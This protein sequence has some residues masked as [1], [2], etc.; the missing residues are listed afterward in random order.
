M[1]R[2]DEGFLLLARKPCSG[3]RWVWLATMTALPTQIDRLAARDEAAL[4]HGSGL[5]KKVSESHTSGSFVSQKQANIVIGE[6]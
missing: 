6:L 2:G 4:G 1:R 3:A 5:A